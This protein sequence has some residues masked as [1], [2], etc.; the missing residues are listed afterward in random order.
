MIGPGLRRLF[1]LLT[2]LSCVGLLSGC[3]DAKEI[4]NRALPV[5][6]G[7]TLNESNEYR[8]LFRIPILGDSGKRFIVVQAEAST[9]SDAIDKL[10]TNM[11][12]S[13]DLLHLKLI[14]ISE[15]VARESIK[16]VTDFAMRTREL[17]PKAFVAITVG[18]IGQLIRSDEKSGENEGTSFY[19]FFNKKAG[20][21]PNVSLVYLW[22][23]FRTVYADTEDMALPLISKGK[24]TMLEFKGSAIMHRDKMVGTLTNDETLIYNLFQG[25]Y[26]GGTVEV[27]GHAS[28]YILK[29][30]VHNYSYWQGETPKVDSKLKL[31]VTL[32]ESKEPQSNKMI[33]K[34]LEVLVKE[35]FEKLFHKLQQ[36]KSDI[37]GIGQ[38]FRNKISLNQMERWKEELYPNVQVDLHVEAIIRNSGN[39]K[40]EKNSSV[41]KMLK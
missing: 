20:W 5:V 25:R 32:L 4:N 40:D 35:R 22:E 26:T 14:L 11:K 39:L 1:I 12:R 7:V 6:M 38:Y 13:L 31:I 36:Q 33:Q 19:N 18:D 23:A 28:V 37:L 27:M 41:P 16:E 24:E 9:I 34:E 3:W 10:R 17:E 30:T 8:V 15:N 21:T 2:I 29:A